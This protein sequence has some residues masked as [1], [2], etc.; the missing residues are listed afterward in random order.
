MSGDIGFNDV[1]SCEALMQ[2]MGE[3]QKSTGWAYFVMSMEKA[4]SYI[5]LKLPDMPQQ[6]DR[7][8]A[9]GELVQIRKALTFPAKMIEQAHAARERL[10]KKEK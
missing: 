3:L 1:A 8:K 4:Q 6:F 9:L 10:K 7:D 2:A 5:T